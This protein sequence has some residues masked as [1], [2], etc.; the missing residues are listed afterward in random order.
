MTRLNQIQEYGYAAFGLTV[1]PYA[2]MSFLN[3][4]GN[5]LC[6][7]YPTIFIV[8]SRELDELQHKIREQKKEHLFPINGTVGRLHETKLKAEPSLETDKT[9]AD[10]FIPLII[11]TV[12]IVIVAVTSGFNPGKSK[13][14]QRALTML[15]LAWGSLFGLISDSPVLS[16]EPS[17]ITVF[18]IF[19]SAPAIACF[20]VVGLMIKEYGVCMKI[21]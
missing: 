9:W 6:P 11:G 3:L 18:F 12:P 14:Y 5:L 8:E 21:N 15:W 20:V 7:Q 4:L 17:T 13:M 1:A 2:T 10:F 16:E 19:M